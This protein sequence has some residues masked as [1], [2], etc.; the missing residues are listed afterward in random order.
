[1]HFSARFWLLCNFVIFAYKSVFDILFY[2]F[3]IFIYNK[4]FNDF[5]I[6]F[7]CTFHTNPY[8]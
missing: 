5:C 3:Y 8:K 2:Y 6:I 4:T 1:M 7:I